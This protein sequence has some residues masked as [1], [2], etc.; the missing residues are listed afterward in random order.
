MAIT[1][2]DEV[3][4]NAIDTAA[5]TR[6][7]RG[8][9]RRSRI[10]ALLLV[11][12]LML[13]LLSVFV[14]PI[15][16][17]LTRSV[18]NSDVS[19]ALP[20]TA[21][22]LSSWSSEHA[23]DEPLFA[24]LAADLKASSRERVAEAAKRLNNYESGIRSSLLKTAR[25]IRKAEAPYQPAFVEADPRWAT[26]ERWAALK[27]AMPRLTDFY[28]LAALDLQRDEMGRITGV[29]PENAVHLDVLIRTFVVSI[30]VTLSCVLLGYPLAAL[31]ARSTGWV[32]NTLLILVLLPFWTSLLVRTSAWVVLLQSR[33]IVNSALIW[34]GLLDPTQP[35][36][37]IYNRAGVLIAMTHILLPFMVL[38]IYSVMKTIPPVYMRAASS[39]GAPP[40]SVFWRVYLPMSMPGVSA[41]GLLVFILAL[42]YYIT[43]AL[44]GGPR[45]QMVSYF[46]AYYANQVTNWGMA[47][48][49]SAILLVAVLVLYALYNRLIGIDRLRIG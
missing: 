22:A 19:L 2:S 24:A 48:A 8:L 7:L 42:G 44:V 43:P 10:K 14:L 32:A 5:L 35:L 13:F 4:R 45:D 37:L 28:L 3:V 49:L 33:G 12:P 46:I 9:R 39:L 41:G 31:M 11:A 15:G 6:R 38:P 23:P 18:D 30:S 27:Q 1:L 34:L 25:T 40:S 47:A 29:A 36:E 26:P 21:T 20:N 17:L 16:L